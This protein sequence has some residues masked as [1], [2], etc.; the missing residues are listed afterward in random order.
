MLEFVTNPV[1]EVL[2]EN[3]FVL[4]D[5][6]IVK[7]Y[8]FTFVID[9]GFTTDFASV[10]RLPVVYMLFAGKAK[11]SAVFHDFL[12]TTQPFSRL[13]ADVAFLDAMEA[14]GLDLFTRMAMYRGVRIGGQ[15]YWDKGVR[16]VVAG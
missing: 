14:E 5:D 7:Y 12:Y 2:G 16:P 10:P 13:D 9:S 4:R 1:V 3:S 6:F 15:S 11:K 8:D